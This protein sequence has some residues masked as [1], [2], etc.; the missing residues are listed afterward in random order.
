MGD[1]PG[2]Q[3]QAAFWAAKRAMKDATEAAFDRHGVRA[4]QQFILQCLWE[5][6]GLTPGEIARR[7]GLATPTVTKAATRM[8]ATG[9]LVRKPHATDARLVRLCLTDRGRTLQ[10]VIDAELRRL[11]RRALK[12]LSPQERVQL[13]RFLTEIRHNLSSADA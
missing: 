8:E 3:F 10:T 4:G 12:T 6:D 9:L 7:L 2:E 13:V 5:K 1:R 11:T